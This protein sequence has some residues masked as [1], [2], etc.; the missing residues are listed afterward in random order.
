[1]LK[2]RSP[3]AQTDELEPVEKPSRCVDFLYNNEGAAVG[4]QPW[5][6]GFL[7][8]FETEC[9]VELEQ[10]ALSGDYAFVLT[11]LVDWIQPALPEDAEQAEKM[12][13]ALLSVR[14]GQAQDGQLLPFEVP[15]AS[16]ADRDRSGVDGGQNAYQIQT[17]EEFQK[18]KLFADKCEEL[19]FAN[20]QLALKNAKKKQETEQFAEALCLCNKVKPCSPARKRRVP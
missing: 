15:A 9:V 12:W 19:T 8:K 16:Y 10:R 2:F 11:G 6:L 4:A 1:M 7:N 14:Q 17:R 20:E 5:T 18:L 13:E 3:P